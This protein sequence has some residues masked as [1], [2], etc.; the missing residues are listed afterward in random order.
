MNDFDCE[1]KDYRA[2]GTVEEFREAVEKQE[3]KKPKEILRHRGGF[4]MQHCSNCDTDYQ[5]DRRYTITD[6]YCPV[7]GKLLDS[8]FKN[9]CGNCGQAIAIK[10]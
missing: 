2:I 4:K 10:F 9:Y 3:S 5:V 1:Y 7:C 6:D 8:A